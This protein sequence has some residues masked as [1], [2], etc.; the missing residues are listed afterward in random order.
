VRE[1]ERERER[2]RKRKRK[3]ERERERREERG[4]R[5]DEKKR[6]TSCKISFK[7]I[8]GFSEA[9]LNSSII[10]FFKKRIKNKQSI[11]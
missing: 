6:E 2:E 8:S 5:R 1:R 3:R 7:K 4:E 11:Q 10:R 9:S